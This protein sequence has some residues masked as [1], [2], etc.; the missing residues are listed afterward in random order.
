MLVSDI[1][2]HFITFTFP[3]YT[4]IS[5]KHTKCTARNFCK[6]N[7][8]NFKLSLRA[9]NWDTTYSSNSASESF[10]NF[11]HDFYQHFNNHF[12]ICTFSASKNSCKIKNFLTPELL[13]ARKLKLNLHKLA[14]SDPSPFNIQN[15]R[16][17]RNGYN[18]AVR[19]SKT[20][21]YE[22]NLA[23]SRNNPKKTWQLLKEAANLDSARSPITELNVNGTLTSDNSLIANSFNTFFLHCWLNYL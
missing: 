23:N 21:Y 10:D 1:S 16:K 19:Q 22:T 5:R 2:D 13:E 17:H 12:P 3:S 4:K 7:I 18:T 14:L 20:S 6:Q 11:W 8:E 9:H 15:Y